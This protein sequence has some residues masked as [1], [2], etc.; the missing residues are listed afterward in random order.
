MPIELWR[1]IASK[2]ETATLLKSDAM[3]NVYWKP[4]IGK[5]EFHLTKLARNL[6]R[7]SDAFKDLS[8][9]INHDRKQ[10]LSKV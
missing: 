1:K 3:K 2:R 7:V 9:W 8:V 4:K 6:D 5:Q 10:A